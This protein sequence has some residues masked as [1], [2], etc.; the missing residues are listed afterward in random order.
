ML[1][2]IFTL[3]LLYISFEN[4]YHPIIELIKILLNK[5]KEC[6]P[7]AWNPQ[8][9]CIMVWEFMMQFGNYIWAINYNL[10]NSTLKKNQW[11]FW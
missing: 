2:F 11:Y 8:I 9:F 5:Q 6:F 10:F 7:Q 4:K 1:E 3:Y